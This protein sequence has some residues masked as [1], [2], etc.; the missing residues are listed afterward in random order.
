MKIFLFVFTFT[1]FALNSYSQV[2]K[3]S[4]TIEIPKTINRQSTKENGTIF[5]VLSDC[6]V[7]SYEIII[8][9][10]WGQTLFTSKDPSKTFDCKSIQGLEGSFYCLIEGVYCNGKK[11]KIEKDFYVF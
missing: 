4:C 9:N 10:R 11:Y 2:C 1:F 7:Q 3:D 8:K 6:P 5:N